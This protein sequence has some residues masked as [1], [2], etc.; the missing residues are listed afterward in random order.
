[1][2][3]VDDN[4]LTSAGFAAGLRECPDIDLIATLDHAEALRWREEW[5]GVDV[6]LVDAADEQAAGDQFPGVQVVRR[7]RECDGDHEPT[8][9]VVTGHFMNDGLR[10]RMAQAQ[11]D[12]FFLRSDFRS[13]TTLREVVLHPERFRRGV[14][15]VRDP[16]TPCALGVTDGT[17]IEELVRY[18][19]ESGLATSFDPSAPARDNPRS[20]RWLRHRRQ[21]AET[22]SIEAVNLTTGQPP[23]GQDVPSLRQLGRIY[24]WAA[25]VRPAAQDPASDD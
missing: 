5:R 21:I 15:A 4:E 3:I 1:M 19:E 16:D 20:R 2:I 8:V 22:A 23:R 12:L 7:I 17:R 18:V 11:A 25:K 13:M 24:R 10:H 14:P 9:V 6:V